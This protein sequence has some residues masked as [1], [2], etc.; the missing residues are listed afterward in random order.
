MFL[1]AVAPDNAMAVVVLNTLEIPSYII[2][3]SNDFDQRWT[4]ENVWLLWAYPYSVGHEKRDSLGAWVVKIHVS[5]ERRYHICF[6]IRTIYGNE[7]CGDPRR[8]GSGRHRRVHG[9]KTDRS[10]P[11]Y[12]KTAYCDIY[13]TQD[14]GNFAAVRRPTQREVWVHRPARH[15]RLLAGA[16]VRNR[17]GATSATFY[18]SIKYMKGRTP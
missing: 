5:S 7:H 8:I 10:R 15:H 1:S 18:P 17:R 6:E 3:V 13:S 14:A 2:G 16:I 9:S 12:H 11:V 4:N